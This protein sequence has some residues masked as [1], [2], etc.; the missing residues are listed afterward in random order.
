MGIRHIVSG[1]AAAVAVLLAGCGVGEGAQEA[2]VDTPTPGA[3][4]GQGTDSTSSDAEPG[5]ASDAAV[6]EFAAWY[7]A[8]AAE[9]GS[10]LPQ[11]L[12]QTD[13]AAR[14]EAYTVFI[15]E[16]CGMN[17]EDTDSRN[18]A[19]AAIADNPEF[20]G[21]L[22]WARSAISMARLACGLDE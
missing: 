22:Q 10:D 4:A 2:D 6:D 11:R 9:A 13:E 14:R 17:A 8:T 5:P 20:G 7:E 16:L 12:R 15:R 3:V 18:A 1:G 21:D 19:G